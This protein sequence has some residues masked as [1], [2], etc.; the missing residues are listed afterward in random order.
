MLKKLNE[1]MR[2]IKKDRGRHGK[3]GEKY[4]TRQKF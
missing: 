2:D 4:A 1:N 3:E